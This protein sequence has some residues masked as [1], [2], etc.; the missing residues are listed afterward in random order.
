MLEI[1]T[2]ILGDHK[3]ATAREVPTG[4]GKGLHLHA[5]ALIIPRKSGKPLEIIAPLPPH[6]KT[7]FEALG[8]DERE[9]GSD[10]LAFF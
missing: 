9:A 10:P 1:E 6:M 5:R 4:V 7:T 3:Y 8:Y 2:S